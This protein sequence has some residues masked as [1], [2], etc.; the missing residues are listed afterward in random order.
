[1]SN[2]VCTG[3]A[4]LPNPFESPNHRPD[5]DAERPAPGA[6]YLASTRRINSWDLVDSSAE[7]L[8]GAHLDPADLD[9]LRQLAT[10]QS[11][12]ERRI[13]ILATFHWIKRGIFPPRTMLR[14][15]SE[16]FPEARRQAYLRSDT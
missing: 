7:H 3:G 13:A 6:R 9:L 15:A 8:V 11:V 5:T 12:W 10:S 1:M 16:R 14:Y 2:P 4:H